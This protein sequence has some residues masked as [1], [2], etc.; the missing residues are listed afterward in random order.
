MRTVRSIILILVW[1]M[2]TPLWSQQQRY[3]PIDIPVR[4][5]KTLAADAYFNSSSIAKPVILIQTPYNK[6]L[7]RIALSLPPQ[8]GG[9]FPYDSASYNYI[10]LDWRGFYG[11]TGA[12]VAGYDRGLDGYDA[13]EWI[14]QQPWC[15]GKIG[16]WGPSALGLIQFQT[17]R[18]KPP[19]LVCSVPVVKDFKNKYTD[20]YYGGALREEHVESLEKLGFTSKAL[21]TAAPTYSLVWKTIERNSDYPDEIS[22]P[23]LLIGG[24]FDHNPDDVMRA[25]QDLR[26]RSD[27][28]V[29][30]QHRLIMGPWEHSR[31][32]LS[33]QGELE[34]PAANGVA[35][36]EA[37]R[38]FDF[39]LRGIENGWTASP[40]IRY[41]ELGGDQWKTANTWSEVGRNQVAL[42]LDNGKLTTIQPGVS[43]EKSVIIYDPRDPSPSYGGARFNPFNPSVKVG[44]LD[45]RQVVE[46]RSDA[47]VFTS[48][49][50]IESI[51]IAGSVT[52]KLWV[53]SDRT[54]TDF[55]VRL[56]DVYPDGRSMIMTDGIERMR[57]RN[58]TEREEL[59]TPG[60][61]YPVSIELQNLALTIEQGHRLRIVIS[62]SDWPRFDRNLNN[63]GPMYTAGDTLIA[64]NTV[65]HN[66]TYP[67]HVVI[68]TDAPTLIVCSS[69]EL[70]FEIDRSFPNPAVNEVMMQFTI[71]QSD[72]VAIE[73]V[74]I[75][76]RRYE[77]SVESL[78]AGKH[79]HTL[80]ISDMLPGVYFFRITANGKSLTKPFLIAR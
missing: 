22:I 8:A 66:G 1:C 34:Y 25:F 3:T 15:N 57:F 7:Y 47:L 50:A 61:I 45:I 77:H 70:R 21:I 5:G 51:R 33:Q 26:E 80:R 46:S 64:T 53:S 13:V 14:A 68:Q 69:D 43:D 27:A 74:D 17:A 79:I 20:Y 2:A 41:Y 60:S 52:V 35:E 63:G 58:T 29:R 39:H 24:W 11:S 10:I 36:T 78:P 9:S 65:Y 6:N 30:S 19:H 40:P 42:Y 23:M 56:C 16:T 67:S 38:F 12:A 48:D 37:L 72:F 75:L 73:V 44:P 49:P 28:N 55:S 76:G 18:H 31:V 4:D 62:A 32:G 54:D 71:P 59:L